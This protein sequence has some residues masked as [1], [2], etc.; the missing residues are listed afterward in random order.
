[1]CTAFQNS[2][3][4]AKEAC[5]RIRQTYAAEKEAIMEALTHLESQRKR[6]NDGSKSAA[7]VAVVATPDLDISLTALEGPHTGKTWLLHPRA[8]KAGLKIGRSTGKA[9]VSGGVSLPE[10]T[11]VSTTHGK[12]R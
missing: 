7:T 11:E 6:V 10:D 4:A 12:V 5:D 2:Q 3:A 9:F 8:G 1:M